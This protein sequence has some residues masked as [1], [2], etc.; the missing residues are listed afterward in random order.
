MNTAANELA[1]LLDS[2]GAAEGWLV[3]LTDGD[4][5]SDLPATNLQTDLEQ[6]AEMRDNMYVQY[7]AMGS[8]IKTVADAK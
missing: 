2:G 1:A 7:L 6:K 8:D 4:F 5:D 3:V